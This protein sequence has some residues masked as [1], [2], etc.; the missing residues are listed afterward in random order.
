MENHKK[1]LI[2]QYL[3]PALGNLNSNDVLICRFYE[4]VKL[5]N[6]IKHQPLELPGSSKDGRLWFPIRSVCHSYTYNDLTKKKQG[7]RVYK[8]R[9]FVF[10]VDSLI[11]DE[12]RNEYI[13]I[14]EPGEVLHISYMELR[15]LM[16][17]FSDLH[18]AITMHCHLQ[19]KYVRHHDLLLKEEPL[20]RLRRFRMEQQEF[21][22][23]TNHLTQALHLQMSLRSYDFYLKMLKDA[24]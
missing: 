6:A 3:L 10:N 20:E 16:Q 7:T 9:Q 17:Q 21:I 1:L 14:L 18:T 19:G 4:L 8:K 11:D 5:T 15:Q 23:C 24:H 12:H 2:D 22:R 13:E